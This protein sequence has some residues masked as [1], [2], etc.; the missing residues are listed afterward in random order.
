MFSIKGWA[1]NV[2]LSDIGQ[3]L[4]AAASHATPEKLFVHT[5][6]NYYLAGE[7][8]WFK[9]YQ[10]D[11]ITH[12]PFSLS[13]VA[14]VEVLDSEN[15]PV[16]QAKVAMDQGGGGSLALPSSM[17]A[18]KYVLRAYTNWMKN[19]DA[20]YFFEKS[21]TVVNTF[22]PLAQKEPEVSVDYMV[23]FFPEGGHLVNGLQ[24]KV[25]FQAVDAQGKGGSFVG[26]VVNSKNDTVA[27]FYT[28][29]FGIGT[30]QLTP[31][32]GQQYRAVFKGNQGQLMT[33]PL[34]EAQGSGVVLQL[35]DTHPDHVS[36]AVTT[37]G[38]NKAS[39]SLLV[40]TRQ[41]V[42]W[43]QTQSVDQQG[44]ATFLLPKSKLAEGIS[45]LTLFNAA[46]QPVSERLYFKRPQAQVLNIKADTDRREYTSRSEV[47]LQVTA[48][49]FLNA[50][51]AAQLSVAVYRLDSLQAP[52]T[53]DILS[54]FYL[55]SDLKGAV[56]DPGY[57]FL[58]M[59][60]EGEIAA[61]NLML[62]HGWSR[63]TWADVLQNPEKPL[64]YIPEVN[65]HLVN[66]KITDRRTGA[67]APGVMTYLAA[68][69]LKVGLALVKS[70][71][72]GRL[73]F[74]MPNLY[75][76]RDV[77]LQTDTRRDSTYQFEILDP[78]STESATRK[79]H[80]LTVTSNL[81][82]RLEA[83]SLHLQVQRFHAPDSTYIYNFPRVDSTAFYGKPDRQYLLDDFTRFP[84]MEDVL[85]EYVPPVLVRKR[86]KRFQFAVVDQFRK[87]SFKDEP[88]VL[89]DGVP[90][91]TTDSIMAYDPKN[92]RQLDVTARKFYMGATEFPGIVS[93]TTYA[94]N[95]KGF[96]VDPRALLVEY[97]GLQ[98]QREFHSPQYGTSEL[99]TSRLPDLRNLLYWNP[100]VQTDSQGKAQLQF[101]TADQKGRYQ[102]VIQGL[103]PDGK[104]GSATHAFE[105]K[106]PDL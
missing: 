33:R 52:E 1:Q 46:N 54:W 10:V 34:P 39:Y 23:R 85:R 95:L 63:F 29:K 98:I 88:L 19:F 35:T 2:L 11:G 8:L 3:K 37:A 65:G 80:P 82:P 71:Q 67:P 31:E 87:E 92:V 86:G 96:Q 66:G 78:F 70:D 90:V 42:Q 73:L 24:S 6:R 28:H 62:T 12:Q 45:H 41:M 68:P 16:V 56:E 44:T 32:V 97:D 9:I 79:P 18:G 72:N 60:R 89:L 75:G 99:Q 93:F 91:F 48:Q 77:V 61:D 30:F 38:V 103:A 4:H 106:Q 36:V 40:H 55:S 7:T 81:L 94:G 76:T 84:L 53:E 69:S 22:K 57:Y 17:A 47:N 105:V 50:G 25:A 64:T 13:K 104:A 27:R 101:F 59:G 15:V 100:T 20:A 21:I 58:D 26:A 102:V 5:D 74:Q 51:Q 14:C 43:V 83:A 49:S